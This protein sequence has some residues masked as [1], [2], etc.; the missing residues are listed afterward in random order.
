MPVKAGYGPFPASPYPAGTPMIGYDNIVTE[1]NIFTS[2]AQ[3]GFPAVNMAN[4][5]TYLSWKG[6]SSSG[7][8]G[9]IFID[10]SPGKLVSYVAFAKHNLGNIGLDTCYVADVS[11][12]PHNVLAQIDP[13]DWDGS[14]PMIV[15]FTPGTYRS[16]GIDLF[17][18]HAVAPQVAVLYCGNLLTLERGV[19][20]D[21]P[22]VPIVFGRRAKT[23]TGIS[24]SG[25]FLGT[26]QPYESRG[27]R[28]EFFGFT[29]DFYRASFD[30]FLD[31]AQTKPFFWAWAPQDYPL[32]V[33][34]SWLTNNPQPEV[35]PDHQ[36]VAV[37]LDMLGDT[38]GA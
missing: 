14:A 10:N 13:A 33:G 7:G 24:E 22:H 37:A 35:S 23:A 6:T 4:P 28:A 20:V 2:T 9:D 38:T 27:T 5:A 34:F 31:V 19:R 11:V 36:R 16:I 15:Y 26:I 18:S 32:E 8:G 30:P 17:R 29:P 12:S 3:A 25:N 1:A 21:V